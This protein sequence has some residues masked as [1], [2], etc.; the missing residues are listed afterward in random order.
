MTKEH[1]LPELPK[2][3]VAPS[4]VTGFEA[5][6][7]GNDKAKLM[8]FLGV[9]TQNLGEAAIQYLNVPNAIQRLASAMGI[10]TEGLVKTQEEIQ[11]E[12][13]AAQQQAQAHLRKTPL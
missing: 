5:L 1:K 4:V 3:M 10:P 6:G 7:R 13:Q 2:G 9:M 12:Q 8:E 11:Q